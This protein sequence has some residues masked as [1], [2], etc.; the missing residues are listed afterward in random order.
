MEQ[1][2]RSG[3]FVPPAGTHAGPAVAGKADLVKRFVA[4]VID[5]VIGA[6]VNLIPLVGGIVAGAYWL[7]RDGLELEF[8]DRRSIGKK[9]MKLR[10]VRLDGAPMDLATS[11]RRNWM[12][13]LGGVVSIL[14]WIPFVGWLLVIPVALIAL[15]I[16]VVELVLALTDAQGRRFGDRLANT[17]VMEVQD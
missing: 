13:A 17:Q 15:I 8:M 11:A 4:V 1:H 2:A 5:G 10:P 7:F 16:G 3:G 6:V 14:F 12:F 9:V